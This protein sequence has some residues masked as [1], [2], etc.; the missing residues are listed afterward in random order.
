MKINEIIRKQ[1]LSK[2][3]TQQ[4]LASYLGVTTPAVNKWEK[5]ITYPDITILP[6]LARLLDTDL[7]T[8]LSFQEDLSKQEIQTF[9]NQLILDTQTNGIQHA[10]NMALT[11]IHEYPTCDALLFQTATL[12]DGLISWDM[13]HS[14]KEMINEIEQIYQRCRKSENLEIKYQATYMLVLKH[15]QNNELKQA[16]ELVETL[17]EEPHYDKIRTQAQIFIKQDQL[18]D[19][20]QILE[21]KL[22]KDMNSVFSTLEDLM[23]IAESENRAQDADHIAT[24]Y[25]QLSKQM[26]FW[27]YQSYIADF[28]LSLLRK[29][30]TECIQIL[31]QM[32][33]AMQDE[34]KLSESTLFQHIKQNPQSSRITEMTLPAMLQDL[35]DPDQHEYDFIKEHPD[36]EQL[37]HTFHTAIK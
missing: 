24:L 37:I 10:F 25:R 18:E 34:W 35:E 8:L 20:A 22:L 1:R 29:N 36:Y 32:I 16:N 4:Q 3:L 28:R 31:M 26:E 27:N 19:A 12:L 6:A 21:Q 33:H 15:M 5:G 17:P 30:A 14:T 11:K 13:P 9:L 2:H 7:N 23:L